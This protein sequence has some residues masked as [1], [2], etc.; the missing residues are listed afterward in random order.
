M[1]LQTKSLNIIALNYHTMWLPTMQLAFP[2]TP[3]SRLCP[4]PLT[5]SLTLRNPLPLVSFQG[6][7]LLWLL[8]LLVAA[9]VV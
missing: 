6:G 5:S 9:R 3:G 8:L 7:G 1:H 4:K 2:V